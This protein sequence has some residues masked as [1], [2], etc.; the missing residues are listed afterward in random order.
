M[1]CE[2]A[3]KNRLLEI[4]CVNS[5]FDLDSLFQKSLTYYKSYSPG[6]SKYKNI[7]KILLD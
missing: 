5:G 7:K 4:V 2:T 6:S 1:F 3:I